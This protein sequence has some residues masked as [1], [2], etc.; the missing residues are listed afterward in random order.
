MNAVLEFIRVQLSKF[1]D[2]FKA[3]NPTAFFVTG[4]LLYAIWFTIDSSLGAGSITDTVLK[5]PV[6]GEIYILDTIKN[7][8]VFLLMMFG[9]HTPETGKPVVLGAVL[10]P[11]QT[12]DWQKGT[13]YAKGVR[14]EQN[15]SVFVCVRTHT[16]A[17]NNQPVVDE[18]GA[19]WKEI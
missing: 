9:A 4:G 6:L 16:S 12:E 3:K 10:E 17:L 5:I 19:Y 8:L 1:V 11:A 13:T 7:V 18:V 2:S 15:E 14:V